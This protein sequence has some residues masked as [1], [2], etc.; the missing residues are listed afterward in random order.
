MSFETENAMSAFTLQG[1]IQKFW[2]GVGEIKCMLGGGG[3]LCDI[4][5]Q[6]KAYLMRIAIEGPDLKCCQVL[7]KSLTL[8]QANQIVDCIAV[9]E[10]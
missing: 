4:P 7:M 8:L 2:L 1:F 9:S 10:K 5:R 3:V 6:K